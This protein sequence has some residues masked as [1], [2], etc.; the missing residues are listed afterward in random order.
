MDNISLWIILVAILVLLV[1]IIAYFVAGRAKKSK[2]SN[3]IES[4]EMK[5]IEISNKPVMFELAKLKSVRKSARIVKMVAD[6]E[7]RWQNLEEQLIII[8]DNIAFAEEMLLVND[9]VK[10]EE[11]IE[12]TQKDLI[13][14]TAKVDEILTEIEN[15]K[16]TEMRNRDGIIKLRGLSTNLH[17][18]FEDKKSAYEDIEKEVEKIFNEVNELFAS[19]DE[20]MEASNY[21]LADEV[22]DKIQSKLDLLEKA[23][24]KIPLY[25]ESIEIDINPMLEGIIES[26]KT[27]LEDGMFLKHLRVEAN[28]SKC[29][30]DLKKIP[31][32]LRGFDFEAVEK[33]LVTIPTD[34]K[35]VRDAMKNEVDIKEIFDAD[36]QK[37]A[38]EAVY[39]VRECKSLN[40]RYDAI[41]D[42]CL[43]RSDDE[44]NFKALSREITFLEAGVNKILDEIEEGNKAISDLHTVVIGYLNQLVEIIEQLKIFDNEIS[45]LYQGSKDVRENSIQLLHDLN[46]LKSDFELAQFDTHIFNFGTILD[47]ANHKV[48]DLLEE[49]SKLP[50]DV[51]NVRTKLKTAVDT[52]DKAKRK[53]ALK[54]EQMKMAERLL[55][56]GNRYIEREGVFLMDLTIAEDQF[57]QGNYETVVD[58]MY[59]ILTDVE[60]N[61]FFKV[62][63][64]LKQE[65]DCSVI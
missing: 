4:L 14:L 61:E 58:K 65:L 59:K 28:I 51:T 52:L 50:V 5:K 20:H 17:E 6:W 31:G 2:Y 46:K 21:D 25:K 57:R 11:V 35:K 16:S 55:V 45:A 18:N 9:F 13:D 7:E 39:V 40:D 53:V 56:Y 41:K 27:M 22:G 8:E 42:S 49:T 36:A 3:S 33:L 37:M 15:L 29:R 24:D 30:K 26:H 23:F 60:G 32:L 64:D 63:E 44:E 10:V 43:M 48:I 38:E 34:A 1:L 62:F 47:D 12:E 19:F 54:I